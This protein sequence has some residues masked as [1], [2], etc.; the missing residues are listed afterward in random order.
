MIFLNAMFSPKSYLSTY[1]ITRISNCKINYFNCNIKYTLQKMSIL[2][3][4]IDIDVRLSLS[5]LCLSLYLS[6]NF[7]LI[8]TL[9]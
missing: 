6:L 9:Q 7:N 4:N 2:V 3:L 1:R 5:V 8:H